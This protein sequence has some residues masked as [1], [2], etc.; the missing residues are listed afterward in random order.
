MR[1]RV[2]VVACGIVYRHINA[3]IFRKTNFVE[4]IELELQDMRANSVTVLKIDKVE[5]ADE[6]KRKT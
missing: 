1:N 3:I 6:I 4:I 5:V 2:N